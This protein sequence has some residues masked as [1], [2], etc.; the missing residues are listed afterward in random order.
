VGKPSCQEACLEANR[1][2]TQNDIG[3]RVLYAS[4]NINVWYSIS[5]EQLKK[6]T[7]ELTYFLSTYTKVTLHEHDALYTSSNCRIG[8]P[9][10]KKPKFFEIQRM[11][12]QSCISAMKSFF[13][14]EEASL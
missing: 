12:V 2:A 9:T 4:N 6:Y 8:M 1:P 7:V 14:A 3:K 13:L 10:L 5:P 11:K